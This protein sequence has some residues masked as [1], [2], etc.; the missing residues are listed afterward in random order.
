MILTKMLPLHID[1][2][3]ELL[4]ICFGESAWSRESIRDQ[5]E[6]PVSYCAVAMDEERVIGYI[7]FER[8]ADEGSLV[9]L[10]VAPKYRKKGIGR[11]LTQLML[12]SCSGMRT[13]CLEVRASNAPAI[14]LYRA[15]GFVPISTRRGY[16]DNPR[17]DAVIMI[18]YVNKGVD[19]R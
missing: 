16:Y 6:N 4:D 2:V 7:A 10:A 14:A 1:G 9:E 15:A 13:V 12:T 17:E 8:I 19:T 5:L 18:Y 11:E 3:K